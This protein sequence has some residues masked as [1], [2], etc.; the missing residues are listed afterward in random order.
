MTRVRLD[1]ETFSEIDIKKRGSYVYAEHPSTEILCLAFKINEDEIEIWDPSKPLSQLDDLYA[2]IENDATICAFNA[3]FEKNIWRLMVKIYGAPEVKPEQWECSAAR[4]RAL[5]LPRSLDQNSDVLQL[6]TPKD[7]AG[8]ALMLKLSKPKKPTKADPR[9]RYTREQDRKEFERLDRYCMTDVEAEEEIEDCTPPL[10]VL[11]KE[12]WHLDQ[13]INDRGIPVDVESARNA[14]KLIKLLGKRANERVKEITKGKIETVGQLEKIHEWLEK[15][16]IELDNLQAK[17]IDDFLKSGE[18]D[19]ETREL[20]L[21]R[22]RFGRSSTHKFQALLDRVS[23][24]DRLRGGLIYAGAGRT[25]RWTGSGFHPLNLKRGFKNQDEIDLAIDCVNDLSI[26]DL[27]MFFGDPMGVIGNLVRPMVKAPE[28]KRF[29][30]ADY[31]GIEARVLSVIAGDKKKLADYSN[32]RDPYITMAAAIYDTTY[33]R[34]TPDQRFFGKTAVLGLGYGMGADKFAA[35]CEKYGQPISDQFANKVV[36]IYRYKESVPVVDFWAQIE[37]DAIKTL[38]RGVTVARKYYQF[39]MENDALV[40]T[41]INGSKR[42]YQKAK[43]KTIERFGKLKPEI[44]YWGIGHANTWLKQQTYGGKLTENLIQSTAR[45]L[46]C[47][48]MIKLEKAGYPI[49]LHQYDEIVCEVDEDQGSVEEL[50]RIMCDNP[51][52]AKDWPI[53]AEGWSGKRYKK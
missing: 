21:L 40:M 16:E 45:E 33:D 23:S 46:L 52:W 3:P 39:S 31:S 6:F 42:Y 29:L 49:V 22:R 1:F 47:P 11:E 44:T 38:S 13:V 10:S 35:Q 34:V 14:V 2:A 50:C 41:L 8:H 19:E 37:A 28:G 51:D 53:S 20:L 7:K 5:A 48:A 27:E 24:D 4:V 26:D 18:G 36:S 9:T 17:T 43:I 25:L 32:K 30:V 15:K 12:I